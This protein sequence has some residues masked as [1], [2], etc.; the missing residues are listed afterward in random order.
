MMIHTSATAIGYNGVPLRAGVFGFW[1]DGSPIQANNRAASNSRATDGQIT[2]QQVVTPGYDNTVWDDMWFFIPYD[3]FPDGRTGDFP[4]YM[5]AQFG[6]DGEGFTAFSDPSTFTYTYPD[7]QLVVD[8]TN[9][10]H[11]VELNKLSGMKV[12]THINALGYQ[13]EK[14]ARCPVRLS[15]AMAPRSRATTVRPPITAPRRA[16]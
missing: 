1:D 6:I 9:I 8:I 3:N 4:A 13:G 11:N 12:H 15:G 2:V 10:E 14:A 16:I 5:E 7:N